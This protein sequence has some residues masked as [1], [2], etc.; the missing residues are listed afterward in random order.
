MASDN[1]PVWSRQELTA[2][3]EFQPAFLTAREKCAESAEVFA[4]KHAATAT[5]S[6]GTG[7][8]IY[9]DQTHL[10]G[11][12]G[13]VLAPNGHLIS[14]Q[15]DAINPDPAHQS[16]IVEFTKTGKFVTQFSIDSTVGAAFG[17]AIAK[18]DSDAVDFAAVDDAT[19]TLTQF[20]FS[21][22]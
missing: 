2:L 18:E 6:S 11:P 4:V 15:G 8:V 12:L 3:R 16:E 14:S 21:E 19:N 1:S 13:L 17:I 10:H 22:Q 9:Q 20:Q 7:T 5:A